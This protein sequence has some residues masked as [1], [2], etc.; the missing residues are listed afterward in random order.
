MNHP[1]VS[2]CLPC[3]LEVD[4]HLTTWD[5]TI[6]KLLFGK[7]KLGGPMPLN[8]NP[9]P[10]TLAN[11]Q[12]NATFFNIVESWR[13]TQLMGLIWECAI[14]DKRRNIWNAINSAM[15]SGLTSVVAKTWMYECEDI[16]VPRTDLTIFGLY[17]LQHWFLARRK[18]TKNIDCELAN[19]LSKK[20]FVTVKIVRCTLLTI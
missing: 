7:R 14:P 16:S 17:R 9:L 5:P 8:Y 18:S 20:Y 3:I 1:S 10:R 11:K 4:Y 15:L 6:W 2:Y 19:N 13:N 12:G